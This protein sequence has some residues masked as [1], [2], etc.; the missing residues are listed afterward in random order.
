ME[1]KIYKDL[2]SFAPFAF[3]YHKVVADGSDNLDFIYLD[4]NEKFLDFAGKSRE[5]L[6]G[7][8]ILEVF[9]KTLS[10]NVDWKTLLQEV[11]F[12]GK[13]HKV[14]YF[15]EMPGR[16]YRISLFS[17]EKGFF[18]A[19][20]TDISEEKRKD[21]ALE[22]FFFINLDLLCIADTDGKF[23]EVNKQWEEILGFPAGELIGRKFLDFVHPDDLSATLE[24][25]SQLEKQSNV[26][27]FVNRYRCKDGSY[28]YIE[29]NSRP[30]DGLVFAAARDVTERIEYQDALRQS[31]ERFRS[32]VN[33][34]NDIIFT[35]D[36]HHRHTGVFGNWVEKQGLTPGFFL[37]KTT[38]EIFGEE[39]GRVHEE[40]IE[41]ALKGEV[42]TYEWNLLHNQERRYFQTVL[43]PMYDQQGLVMGVSGLGRDIS[44]SK[45]TIELQKK[46]EV[47]HKT[48]HFKQ[49]FLAS[50]SHEIRTPL[51]GVMGI[52]ELMQQTSLDETQQD[53]LNAL[54]HSSENLREIIDQVLDYSRLESGNTKLNKE[55]F[56]TA[57]LGI[58]AR[59]LF[60]NL[61]RKP[62]DFHF[63]LDPQVPVKLVAD[64]PRLQ[65]VVDN[66][67]FNAVNHTEQGAVSL[68]IYLA[69]DITSQSCKVKVEVID[70]GEGITEEQQKKVFIPFTDSDKIHSSAYKGSGLGLAISNKIVEMHGG[71]FTLESSPGKGSVFKFSFKAEIPPD[72]TLHFQDVESAR[73]KA[74]GSL[75]I[76]V[77]EDQA[78]TRKVVQLLLNSL[79]HTVILANNG[80]QALELFEEGAF[81]LILMDI[82]MPVMDGIT[83]THQLQAKY[84]NLPRI[85]GFSANAFEGDREKFISLGMDDF[86]VKPLSATSV[87]KLLC[88]LFHQKKFS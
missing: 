75:K 65:K 30:R 8:S 7:K 67:I 60:L 71:T 22:D 64:Y 68:G 54:K 84:K 20:L 62:V 56:E 29:W 44:S 83:A 38:T 72:S 36:I 15:Y 88:R 66:L 81:D 73:I 26:L 48:L 1:T 63:Y 25:M 19:M 79:G 78:I 24:A 70:T 82:Q 21:E 16:W 80:Q 18:A 85:V 61:C 23:L 87:K 34:L 76:L 51:T 32:L 6:L 12:E 3:A 53:Y 58:N 74:I 37:G 28:R 46:I 14:D 11:A 35:L 5:E 17:P 10:D 40:A 33:S 50:M 13:T 57:A 41:K 59:K 31:E 39:N 42:V 55:V 77:A 49:N 86:L 27:G 47:A 4:A 45:K 9:P 69:E 43:S 52:V 2:L